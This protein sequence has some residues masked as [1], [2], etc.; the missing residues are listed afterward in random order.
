MTTTRR[1]QAEDGFALVTA[2]IVLSIIL[3]LGFVVLQT[4]DVQT[5][6]TGY[7]VAGEAAFNLAESALDA[8]AFQLEQAW[9]NTSA[10]AYPICNQT[11]A[12]G[13]GCPG[14]A[15]TSSFNST[16]AGVSYTG[17]IWTAQVVDDT[18]TGGASYYSDSLAGPSPA[19]ISWDSNGDNRLWVRAEATIWGQRKIVVE[20]VVRQLHT[21]VLPQNVV[22]SGGLST[23]NNGNKI[24]I[25]ANDSRGGL[26]AE[27][28]VRCADSNTPSTG[29]PCLGWNGGQGQLDP[30]GNYQA[31]YVD[32]NGGYATLSQISLAQLRTTA[33]AEGAGHYYN[34]TCPTSLIGL[35]YVENV[36]GTCTVNTGTYNSDSAPGALIFANGALAFNA[37]VTYT[38]IVYMAD[39]Q[40]TTPLSGPC[41]SAQ[42]NTVL[43]VQGGAAIY[44][45]L[46]VDKCGTVDAGEAQFDVNYDH[47]AFSGLQAYATPAAA[48]NTFKIVPN[49]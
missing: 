19:P 46:F 47:T 8:E 44:G 21:V 23:E 14:T 28:A 20:Q 32:P 42:Q 33:I 15:L 13:P 39:G 10:Q 24:I 18:G 5:H 25:E 37:N 49:S 48:K 34:G 41:T 3:L 1:H 35:V 4:A 45:G 11:S 9:P 12:P 26:S 22:T 16:Y 7:E 27:V 31:G 29:D 6:Q 17:A 36:T 2:I 30:P 38:G 43:T 40:G